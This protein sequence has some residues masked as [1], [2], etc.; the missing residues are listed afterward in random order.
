MILKELKED[1]EKIKETV[2]KMKSTVK[3]ENP[4]ESS[5]AWNHN[6]LCC[7]MQASLKGI[8]MSIRAGRR[9][10]QRTWRKNDGDHQVWAIKRKKIKVSNSQRN[11]PTDS[12]EQNN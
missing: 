2:N 8:E 11:E 10:N 5:G 4:K 9:Q 6:N 3:G 7:E 12:V 1:K